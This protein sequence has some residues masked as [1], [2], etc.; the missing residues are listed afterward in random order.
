MLGIEL[1]EPIRNDSEISKFLEKK[2]AE[3]IHHIAYQVSDIEYFL[4][5]IQGVRI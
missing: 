3:G 4:K 5:K 2:E 1:M